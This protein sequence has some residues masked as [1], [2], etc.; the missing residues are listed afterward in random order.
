M[1]TEI[2]KHFNYLLTRFLLGFLTRTSLGKESFEYICL[3]ETIRLNFSVL[4]GFSL[5]RSKKDIKLEQ[6]ELETEIQGAI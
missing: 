4:I 3:N 2:E 1:Q 6:D 5:Y